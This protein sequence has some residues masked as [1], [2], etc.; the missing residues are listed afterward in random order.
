MSQKIK[1]IS[2]KGTS[3]YFINYSPKMGSF[4]KTTVSRNYPKILSEVKL[5]CNNCKNEIDYELCR[6]L[7]MRNIDNCP[8]FF[9][10]HY[11]A[12]CW[13]FEDFCQE[14]P[15][16]TLDKTG[17][18]IPEDMKISENGVKNLQSNPSLWD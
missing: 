9:S 1:I 15:N 16:L 18:S 6:I 7:I 3:Y 10:F 12:P 4:Q 14:H 11:F 8:Q 2:G 5:V 13:N 17:V